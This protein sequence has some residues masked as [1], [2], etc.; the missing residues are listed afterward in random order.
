MPS[1]GPLIPRRRLGAELRRLREAAGLHLE[2][3]A[4][5]LECS[6]SKISRL[7]TGQGIPKARDVRDLLALYG[8]DDQRTQ[9]RLLR[10]AGDGRRQAWWQ[11][12]NDALTSNLDQY[13]SLESEA[14][15]Q[16]SFGLS[17]VFAQV[18]TE[19]YARALFHGMFPHEP[20]AI[21]E[22]RVE[23]RM[24]RQQQF[25]ART[26]YPRIDMLLDE[27][28]LYRT[29]GS[30]DIMRGQLDALLRVNDTPGLR[31]RV[32]PFSAVPDLG[33][34]CTFVVFTFDTDFDRHTV[35]LELPGGD[36]WLEM[37]ADVERYTLFFQALAE[38]SLGEEDTAR[39]ITEAR[40]RYE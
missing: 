28:A 37:E 1:Q 36:R 29:V 25:R 30:R 40:S 14:S 13:I 9:D 12:L 19:E 20:A 18:Q 8:L 15:L 16:R 21:L 5:H 17:F 32:H 24:K 3:A 10:L 22:Q 2:H 11:D 23:L 26:D 6:T 35:N 34:Q 27:S 31:L 38:K 7:E 33:A 39:L 4:A